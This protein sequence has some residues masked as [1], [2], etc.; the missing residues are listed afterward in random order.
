MRIKLIIANTQYRNRYHS[1]YPF[2]M[3]NGNYSIIIKNDTGRERHYIALGSC[4][5]GNGGE[6]SWTSV[7]ASIALPPNAQDAMRIDSQH[8][9]V[10]G[11]APQRLG[12]GV[13]VSNVQSCQVALGPNTSGSSI[14]LSIEAGNM[15]L[16]ATGSTS[17]PGVFQLTTDMW[18]PTQYSE[19]D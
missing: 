13:N 7:W 16:R 3:S 18:N 11:M 1:G 5:I 4:D 10:C 6:R 8:Y 17:Q 15:E 19:S 14:A 2:N 12:A 9:A